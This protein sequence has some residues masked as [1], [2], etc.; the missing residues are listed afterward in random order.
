M[1]G[2]W[3]RRSLC[4]GKTCAN[5]NFMC[6]IFFPRINEWMRKIVFLFAARAN[7]PYVRARIWLAMNQ[8]FGIL[9][10]KLTSHG[11]FS[12]WNAN[13]FTTSVLFGEGRGRRKGQWRKRTLPRFMSIVDIGKFNH[14]LIAFRVV[15]SAAP[16]KRNKKKRRDVNLTDYAM[17]CDVKWNLNTA[18]AGR[19]FESDKIH[20]WCSS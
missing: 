20:V 4:R 10:R 15:S 18:Q 14:S 6:V 7:S 2:R 17:P 12:R 16:E 3:R 1:I 8:L 9:E 13:I 11:I 5:L 19:Y